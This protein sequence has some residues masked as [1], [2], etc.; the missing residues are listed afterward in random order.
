MKAARNTGVT[1]PRPCK[2]KQEFFYFIPFIYVKWKA[3]NDSTKSDKLLLLQ[4]ALRIVK[5]VHFLSISAKIVIKYRCYNQRCAGEK[6]ALLDFPIVVSSF[7]FVF[8]F[9]LKLNWLQKCSQKQENNNHIFW[10]SRIIFCS[11]SINT[12]LFS[13]IC[14]AF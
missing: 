7:Q 12:G 9:F 8:S 1:S 10:P 3:F 5:T 6:D 4:K 11:H 2:P 14:L 13:N